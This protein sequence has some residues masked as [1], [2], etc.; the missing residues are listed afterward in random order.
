MTK[1]NPTIQAVTD[2]IIERSAPTR[3]AYL[4]R[5]EAA[6]RNKP[7]RAELSC[8][9][10]AHGFAACG[11]DEKKALAKTDQPNIGIVTAYN[12]MLSAH[13]PLKDYPDMIKAI[14]VANGGVAQVAGGV[15]AMCDGVTQ[16]QPGME[17]SLYSRDVIAMATAVALSHNMFDAAMFLGTCDKIV[18][19]LVIGALSFGHLPAVFLPAGPMGTGQTNDE[20]AKVR[21]AFA[22]GEIGREELLESESKSYHSAGTCTFYGTANSNQM[23]M[24][25]MGLHVPG[26]TFFGPGTLARDIAVQESTRAALRCIDRGEGYRPI[27][28]VLDERAFVNGL[29]GLMATGGSTNLTLHIIAMAAAGGIRLTWDDMNDISDVTPL[30]AKVY[31][32]G[33]AD[34]NAMEAAGGLPFL[35]DQLRGAG[36]LHADAKTITENGLADYGQVAKIATPDTLSFEPAPAESLMPEVLTTPDKPFQ[37]NGGLK[38]LTGNLGRSVI[39]ISAVAPEHRFI[40]AP[41]KVFTDQNQIQAA[42]KAGELHGD[43][44]CV[45]RSQGPKANGMPELHKLTPPL[46]VLQKLGFKVALVTDG[47]MSGAS[48]KVPSAIHLTPEASDGGPIAKIRDGDVIRLDAE[49]GGLEVLVPAEEF[50][51]REAAVDDISQSHILMGRELFAA[52]RATVGDSETGAGVFGEPSLTVPVAS[53]TEKVVV[54]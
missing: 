44:V 36:F 21:E 3:A 47:R 11:M 32:N 26:T 14:A 29:V 31:P 51:A 22:K 8:G 6:R 40:E 38:V 34:V 13:Q 2:R 23:L 42:F 12:D 50:D 48:G 10:L 37:P 46:S 54:G 49:N 1:L 41:A 35:I 5:I 52:F 7:H 19:G 45:L 53:D 27:G 28:H 15:P 43:F 4:E 33:S 24:E 17:L 16:G 18:P 9:N 39:K 25:F 20:K 30:L